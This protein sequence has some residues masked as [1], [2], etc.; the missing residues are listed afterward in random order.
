MSSISRNDSSC[1][2][3]TSLPTAQQTQDNINRRLS[4]NLMK[5]HQINVRRKSTFNFSDCAEIQFRRN[6]LKCLS[7][8]FSNDQ[9]IRHDCFGTI[10]SKENKKSVRVSFVDNISNKN[11]AEVIMIEEKNEV[12]KR[13]GN[14]NDQAV[15]KCSACQI[16]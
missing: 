1:F 4:L 6:H 16:F 8:C 7:E 9:G 2:S 3:P 5:F 13:K 12:H 10:I 11:I 14:D 15:C